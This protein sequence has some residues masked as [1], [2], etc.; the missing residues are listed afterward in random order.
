MFLVLFR[1]KHNLNSNDTKENLKI[2]SSRMICKNFYGRMKTLWGATRLKIKNNLEL[3]DNMIVIC[4]VLINYHIKNY[5]LRN[6][7]CKTYRNF[8]YNSFYN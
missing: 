4:V 6:Q 1:K 8:N 3:Y 5:P 7:D 2:G